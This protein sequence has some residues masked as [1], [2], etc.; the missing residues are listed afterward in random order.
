MNVAV[1]RVEQPSGRIVDAGGTWSRD[2]EPAGDR[3]SDGRDQ[4]ERGGAGA[5]APDD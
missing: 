5:S 1:N 4:H 3:R 2:A